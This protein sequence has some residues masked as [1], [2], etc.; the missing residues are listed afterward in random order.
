MGL[1][2]REHGSKVAM[3]TS[4]PLT[5]HSDNFKVLQCLDRFMIGFFSGSYFRPS[6]LTAFAKSLYHYK[7]GFG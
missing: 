2:H 5:Q 4:R 6:Q 3:G 7:N 1:N